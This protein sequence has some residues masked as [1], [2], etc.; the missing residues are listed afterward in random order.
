MSNSRIYVYTDGMSEDE[1]PRT[2]VEIAMARM[3]QRDV[4]DGINDS[5]LS[6]QQKSAISEVRSLHAAKTAQLDILQ[7]SRLATAFEPAQREQLEAEYRDELRRLNDDLERK[8]D[9]IR[10]AARD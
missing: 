9:K 10:R 4:E 5:P 6:D 7:Q 3:K 1:R 2:A 8:I